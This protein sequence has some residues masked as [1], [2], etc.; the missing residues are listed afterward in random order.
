M[1][2]RQ[3][4]DEILRLIDQ[5]LADQERYG[6]ARVAPTVRPAPETVGEPLLSTAPLA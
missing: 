1:T 3:R 6:V 5:A 2:G 4:C